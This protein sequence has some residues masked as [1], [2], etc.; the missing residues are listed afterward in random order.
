M[1]RVIVLVWR[2]K[3]L[4][5][6]LVSLFLMCV[7]FALSAALDNVSVATERLYLRQG[8][9]L[10]LCT[11]ILMCAFL[12]IRAC[13]YLTTKISGRTA[14]WIGRVWF[15]VVLAAGLYLRLHVINLIPLSPSSDFDTFYKLGGL[16]ANGNLLNA[17]NRQICQYVATFP[18]TIGFPMLVLEPVFSIFGTSVHTALYTNVALSMISVMLMYGIGLKTA[19]RLAGLIAM[20]LMSFWPSHILYASMVASEPA[21][22]FFLLLTLF[23]TVLGIGIGPGSLYERKPGIAIAALIA[24]GVTMGVANSIRPTAVVLAIAVA[25]C[26]LIGGGHGRTT[27]ES[28]AARQILSIRWLVLILILV[29]F[30]LT[31]FILSQRVSEAIQLKPAGGITASGY[32]LLIGTNVESKGLWNQED[33]D[34]LDSEFAK[35]GSAGQAQQKCMERALT[36]IQSRPEDVFDLMVYKF[37]DLWQTDDFGIDWNLLWAGQQGMLTEQLHSQLEAIRPAGRMAYFCLLTLCAVGS[38]QA[39]RRRSIRPAFRI[40]V[41]FFLGTAALHMV[42]ETQVRYH[43]SVT[44]FMIL[45]AVFALVDFKRTGEAAQPVPAEA[46]QDGKEAEPVRLVK[47]AENTMPDLAAAIRDGHVIITMS[48]RSAREA[49]GGAY[50]REKRDA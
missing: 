12:V 50:A 4:D 47:T 22:T 37:R 9:I 8:T 2:K 35:T 15:V 32:N 48:E 31:G 49:L 10:L 3:L 43:Y 34:Y 5:F 17:A 27:V 14:R 45:A 30:L 28:G 38:I 40:A 26:I 33:A 7:C 25:L 46:V 19:G 13:G 21:F 11:A 23:L 36:Y 29:P 24:A 44:P 41:L 16:L 42:L 39:L 1:N 20:T 18:H 6:V